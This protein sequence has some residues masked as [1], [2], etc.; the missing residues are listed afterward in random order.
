MKG[1]VHMARKAW[2]P[3]HFGDVTEAVNEG[4]KARADA[5]ERLHLMQH[6]VNGVRRS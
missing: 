6:D 2:R 4:D 3:S 5:L 1:S